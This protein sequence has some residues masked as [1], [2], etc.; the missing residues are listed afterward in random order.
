[1]YILYAL[2]YG[3]VLIITLSKQ[4][5]VPEGVFRLTEPLGWF[6]A[7]ARGRKIAGLLDAEYVSN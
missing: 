1:M 7:D 3:T 5:A 4:D 6:D 2:W